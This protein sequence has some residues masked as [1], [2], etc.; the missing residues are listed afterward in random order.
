MAVRT[1]AMASSDT[2]TPAMRPTE[3]PSSASSASV[4]G[5]ASISTS[6]SFSSLRPK[7]SVD[8]LLGWDSNSTSS[9]SYLMERFSI[10]VVVSISVSLVAVLTV[11]DVVVVVLA[12][13]GEAVVGLVVVVTAATVTFICCFRLVP[14][15]Q[16]RTYSSSCQY[17][18]TLSK[19]ARCGCPLPRTPSPQRP[20][21]WCWSQWCRTRGWRSSRPQSSCGGDHCG[22][23]SRWP[24]PAQWIPSE[25]WPQGPC[26]LVPVYISTL[27]D[28]PSLR[29]SSYSTRRQSPPGRSAWGS[30][31][32]AGPGWSG[33]SP[34]L[35]TCSQLTCVFVCETSWKAALDLANII[36][37]VNFVAHIRPM[38]S[39][40]SSEK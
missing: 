21:H 29:V 38:A 31:P 6:L 8:V 7:D 23:P 36:R 28:S 18:V 12:V 33:Q 11:V 27:A 2:I 22:T 15:D 14:L 3:D 24:C 16:P 39:H 19:F 34:T 30:G 35:R 32:A 13:L 26:W 9:S 1:N 4:T 25:S 37:S 20:P 10:K 5:K 17:K 40:L